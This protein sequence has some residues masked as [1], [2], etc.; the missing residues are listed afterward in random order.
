MC[1]V[2]FVA[3]QRHMNPIFKKLNYKAQKHLHIIHAPE[4]FGK[5]MNEMTTL[6]AIKTSL[7][8]VKQIEFFLGF[9]TKQ[10]E[11]DELAKKISAL[12]EGDAVIWLAYPKG[13]SKK[14]TCEFN[15]DTGWKELGKAGYEPV[16]MVAINEDWSAVRFR[17]TENIKTMSRSSAISE[18][19]KK[20]IA[21]K[22]PAKKSV[23]KQ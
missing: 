18:T 9:V 23:A 7:A 2:T 19:G 1:P 13:T 16:R 22:T 11:V 21:K 8:G 5:D 15:R 10:K 12:T 3:S 6:A 17:K 20:R 14:Y 4:S